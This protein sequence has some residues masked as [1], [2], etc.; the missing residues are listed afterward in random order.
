MK[1][2]ILLI[3]IIPTVIL[4]IA[5]F[6]SFMYAINSLFTYMIE[7]EIRSQQQFYSNIENRNLELSNLKCIEYHKVGKL[8]VCKIAVPKEQ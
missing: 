8:E 5:I 7:E 4:A 1:N 6:G 2:K 3:A